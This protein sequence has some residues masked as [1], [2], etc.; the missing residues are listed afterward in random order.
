M[1]IRSVIFDFDGTLI[2]SKPGI[3]NCFHAV[4]S[5]HGV[6]TR[7]VANWVIGP[8][9][10]ESMKRLMPDRDDTARREFL[11]DYRRCYMERGWTECSLYAGVAELLAEVRAVG[12]AMYLCTS[13]RKD[14][15][16]RLLDHFGIATYFT[17]VAA[18]EEDLKSH[19]KKDLLR[20]LIEQEKIETASCA[21]VGDSRYDIE[22]ARASG[23]KAVAA[24]YGY[25]NRIELI[26]AGADALCD[27][28]YEVYDTLLSL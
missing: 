9:A 2:D 23:A 8:P 13:K 16:C 3:V 10:N 26:T 14:I 21:V 17:A 4:G 12:L 6:D 1:R 24:L 11:A 28:P 22:A 18:D 15:T 19:D 5:A 27:A 25:G 20:N 7:D